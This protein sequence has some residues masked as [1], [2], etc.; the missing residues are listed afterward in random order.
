[1]YEPELASD[2]AALE[3]SEVEIPAQLSDVR[4]GANERCDQRL[5]LSEC[6]IVARHRAPFELRRLECVLHAPGGRRLAV[7][8]QILHPTVTSWTSCFAG[9]WGGRTA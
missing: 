8:L 4:L 3:H 6:R 5:T 1:M 9:G 7:Q 2:A